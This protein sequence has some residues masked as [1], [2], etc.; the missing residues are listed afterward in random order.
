MYTSD[1]GVAHFAQ[2]GK[3]F[4]H[5]G[6]FIQSVKTFNIKHLRWSNI[7]KCIQKMQEGEDYPRLGDLLIRELDPQKKNQELY[8][9]D[10]SNICYPQKYSS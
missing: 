6:G 8:Y 4:S 7:F 2:A 1:T 9:A 10:W 5:F 3:H